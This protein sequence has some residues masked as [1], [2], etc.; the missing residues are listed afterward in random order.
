M[1]VGIWAIA[2]TPEGQRTLAIDVASLQ[3]T[4]RYVVALPEDPIAPGTHRVSLYR[5]P[6]LL[7]TLALAKVVC[8]ALARMGE[9]VES[10][11][12]SWPVAATEWFLW[13]LRSAL[14]ARQQ[15]IFCGWLVLACV[16]A[17]PL[18]FAIV[19][20]A[21][22]AGLIRGLC[23]PLLAAAQGSDHLLRHRLCRADAATV[24]RRA[25]CEVWVVPSLDADFPYPPGV[26]V[27]VVDHGSASADV[28]LLRR[29][30]AR[31][32]GSWLLPHFP[33]REELLNCPAPADPL[34]KH[35]SL[36]AIPRTRRR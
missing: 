7:A 12:H 25:R 3:G 1:R 35:T 29:E 26:R 18:W 21:T 10:V 23:L 27:I 19:L 28:L 20:S 11:L 16:A 2:E 8:S 33:T 6:R 34:Q 24:I 9:S 30:L 31:S 4:E 15:I 14:S 32:A 17:V 13:Q 5:W 22:F 36:S